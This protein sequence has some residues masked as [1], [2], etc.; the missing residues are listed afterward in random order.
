MEGNL[1]FMDTNKISEPRKM[2]IYDIAK[3]AGVSASTVSRVL[4]NNVGVRA[5]KRARILE[6]ISQYNFRPNALA[7]SLSDTK[8]NIIGIIMA[9]VRNPFYADLFVA[10]EQE[11]R[12]A[13]Y[14]LFLENSLSLP[15]IEE[16][17]LIVMEE[18]RVDA[19]ILVGG[20]ADDLNSNK[21]F[22]EKVNLV[23]NSIPVIVAGKLDGTSCHQVKIDA[24]KSMDI[25]M[26]YLLE[27]NHKEIAFI[28]GYKEVAPTFEKRQRYKQILSRNQITYRPEFGENY[29][30]YD[31]ET[32]Y[33]R[34]NSLFEKNV[35]P[36]AVI[37]IN[38]FTATGVMHSILKHGLRIPED[39]SVISYDNT[40]ICDIITPSLTSISYNY[41]DFAHKLI[42]TAISFGT[43]SSQPQ[44]QL[45]EPSLVIR[46]S[47]AKAK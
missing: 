42:T 17:Q 31:Y 9:D 35:L 34:M 45:V 23:S 24:I 18:Q 11:A 30:G 43:D 7:R 15:E 32:G 5:D 6:L 10:C 4:T 39:I 2:T 25:I 21:S 3:E 46:S 19:I 40:Y 8:R 36:T 44:L 37:A 41:H 28:G 12:N 33:D 13:G 1:P 27:L 47:C 20:R 38:D 26:D 16:S 14:S 29:G 22:V